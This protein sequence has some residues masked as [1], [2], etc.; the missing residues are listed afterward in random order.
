MILDGGGVV[1]RRDLVALLDERQSIIVECLICV[2]SMLMLC[3]TAWDQICGKRACPGSCEPY[4]G[5]YCSPT[6]VSSW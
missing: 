1:H 3:V 5:V 6:A 4:R 2:V